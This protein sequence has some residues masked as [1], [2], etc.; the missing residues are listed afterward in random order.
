VVACGKP[1]YGHPKYDVFDNTVF[2]KVFLASAGGRD[3]VWASNQQNKKIISFDKIDRN[4]LRKRM[5]E[6][7]NR[8]SL[9]FN[10]LG[11]KDKPLWDYDCKDSVAMAVCNNAVVVACK[12][13]IVALDLRNGKVL[14]SESVPAAPVPWGLAIDR[15][16]R[17]VVTLEDG[18]ILCFGQRV[19][20]SAQSGP[21]G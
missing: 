6:P 19:F 10:R 15:D 2:G 3:I 13:E 17:V 7:R 4:V 12:S 18:R 16:G 21:Q 14:W 11:I 5:A 20:A 1:F 9:D 8:F